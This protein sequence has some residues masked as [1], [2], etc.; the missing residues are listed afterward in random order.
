MHAWL[1]LYLR[2]PVSPERPQ[3]LPIGTL[4][5]LLVCL[6]VLVTEH[7]LGQVLGAVM[8]CKSSPSH[9]PEPEANR[10]PSSPQQPGPLGAEAW[11]L[12]GFEAPKVIFSLRM[13]YIH[14]AK[15]CNIFK[16]IYQII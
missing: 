13:K 15:H 16:C 9:A 7:L 1:T 3:H 11:A 12:L 6:P 2:L 10:P 14:K 4:P 5:S 8:Q